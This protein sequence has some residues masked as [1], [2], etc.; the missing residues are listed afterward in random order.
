MARPLMMGHVAVLHYGVQRAAIASS[1]EAQQT[2]NA[3]RSTCDWSAR[4]SWRLRGTV[5]SKACAPVDA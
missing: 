2:M 4:N 1:K 5:S 3:P